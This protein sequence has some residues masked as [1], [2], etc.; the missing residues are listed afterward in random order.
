[1]AST[2][3]IKTEKRNFSIRLYNFNEKM[4]NNAFNFNT[5]PQNENQLKHFDKYLKN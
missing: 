4:T 1:M 5:L 3:K 2:K